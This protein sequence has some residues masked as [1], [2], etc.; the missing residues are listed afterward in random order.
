MRKNKAFMDISVT[1]KEHGYFYNPDQCASRLKTI[2]RAY[3]SVKDNNSKS[4]SSRKTYE[5]EK[6]LDDLYEKRPNIKP[7]FV[8]SSSAGTTHQDSSCDDPAEEAISSKRASD[9]SDTSSEGKLSRPK[10]RKTQISE[11]VTFLQ[12]FT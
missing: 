1:F 7:D 9:E 2:T 10:C 12:S 8:L 11:V 3:K 6:D 5:Y 4:G